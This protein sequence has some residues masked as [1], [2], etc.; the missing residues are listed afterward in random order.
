ME[1]TEWV[2]GHWLRDSLISF[3]IL[4][5]CCGVGYWFY[6]LDLSEANIITVFIV[7]ILATASLTHSNVYGA[8][9][10]IV[11]VLLFNFLFADPLF[12]FQ[13][14]DT[15]YTFTIAVM[16]VASFAVNSMAGHLRRQADV[17]ALHARRTGLLLETNQT[18][19]GAET[20]QQVTAI[21]AAQLHKMLGKPVEVYLAEDGVL[22]E[23]HT[24]IRGQDATAFPLGKGINR[25]LLE[26]WLQAEERNESSCPLRPEYPRWGYFVSHPSGN[27]YVL[28]G[29]WFHGGDGLSKFERGLLFAI[30]DEATGAIQRRRLEEENQT[31][32][33]QAEAQ[34][35]RTDLLRSVSHDLRTPLTGIMGIADIL[36]S[37]E[38]KMDLE[39]RRQFY[40]DIREDAAWLVGM[41]EN[42]LYVTRIEN[43]TIDLDTSP[44][45][46]QELIQG[47]QQRL[48]I[49]SEEHYICAH[50]PDEPILVEVDGR[51][52][53]QLIINLIDNALKYTPPGSHIDVTA[54]MQGEM[55]LVE[56]AD[57]GE[58]IPD[59]AKN[60]VFQRFVTEQKR[61][62]DSRKGIGLGLSICKAI[63]HSHGGQIGLRD[64]QPKGSV[65][66][67]TL[68]LCEIEKTEEDVTGEVSEP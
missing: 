14:Y 38:H 41:V 8:V 21:T 12:N 59:E 68:P 16:L 2:G 15:Q 11:G 46:L 29:V 57:D 37:K 22:Q 65:F 32:I 66:W 62:A 52:V 42:L 51:L 6:L 56:V 1:R 54:S 25:K 67:F 24:L 10:S 63:V 58:G 53:L 61:S 55:A 64:N 40:A 31:I 33:R 48:S 45:E 27:L 60:R 34:K 4:L 26:H 20:D 36:L 7:G 19:Q 39:T 44:E 3:V 43:G 18:L 50:V 28:A 47:A 17:E 30:L 13:V 49:Q 23:C 35:T 9:S 5:F